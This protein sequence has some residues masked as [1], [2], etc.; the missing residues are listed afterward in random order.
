[1][2]GCEEIIIAA[3]VAPEKDKFSDIRKAGLKAV[4][5][6]LSKAL[7]C[8]LK[9]IQRM[10]NDFPFRYAVHASNDCYDPDK[11]AKLVNSIGAEVVVFH[12][13]YW[14]D[15]WKNIIKV[16]KDG[17]ANICVEN[18]STVDDP[19]KFMI[20]YGLGR[21]L[22]FEHLEME[23]LG[24]YG[25]EAIRVIKQACH[26]HLTGYVYN[27]KLWHT[28]IHDSPEHSLYVLNL[29]KKA[30]YRRFVVSEARVSFQMYE[31]FKRLNNFYEMWSQSEP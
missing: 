14:E 5:L 9:E 26:I 6:Y 12:N 20:R 23:C 7:M 29:L 19:V 15:E 8:N 25:E 10:C 28:H 16:F 17:K 30:G 21:C 13:I 3:K 4:E 24:I 2:A 11:L 27:S 18:I 22:D 1:M 31:D